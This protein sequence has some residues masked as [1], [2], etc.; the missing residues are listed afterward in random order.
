M[1]VKISSVLGAHFD[2]NP[3]DACRTLMLVSILS[4]TEQFLEQSIANQTFLKEEQVF[5]ECQF[6]V[7]FPAHS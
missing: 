2:E 4:S 3:I 6:I 1:L 5:G 7:C